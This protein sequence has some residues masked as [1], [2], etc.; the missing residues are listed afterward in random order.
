MLAINGRKDAFPFIVSWISSRDEAFEA[1]GVIHV[2]RQAIV[3]W[4]G[5]AAY[6]VGIAVIDLV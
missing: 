4:K 2:K 3:R 1:R 5:D 6:G